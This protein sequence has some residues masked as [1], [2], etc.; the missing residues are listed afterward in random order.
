MD[1]KDYVDVG[2][3]NDANGELAFET[4]YMT[5]YLSESLTDFDGSAFKI[6]KKS[7]KAKIKICRENWLY[8]G[9]PELP[10]F[11]AT[12]GNFQF[13]VETEDWEYVADIKLK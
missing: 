6:W 1:E 10:M 13:T 4:I 12:K 7:G 8:D 5:P 11:G 9:D 3:V 2:I